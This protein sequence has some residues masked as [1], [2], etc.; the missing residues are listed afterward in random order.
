MENTGRSASI[1]NLILRKYPGW[2]AVIAKTMME[3]DL[4]LKR[5]VPPGTA[6]GNHLNCS[7]N[8]LTVSQLPE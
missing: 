2:N 6:L 8:D 7:V 1:S 4:I 3:K 5:N